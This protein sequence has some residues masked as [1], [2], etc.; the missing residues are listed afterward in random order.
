MGGWIDHVWDSTKK[1][2]GFP[3]LAELDSPMFNSPMSTSSTSSPRGQV[4]LVGAGPGDP[5]LV[6]LRA[7]QCLQRA[8]CVLYD[9]LVNPQILRHARSDAERIRL[10]RRSSDRLASQ[11]EINRELVERATRGQVVVRLKGGDPLVFGRL[12]EEA[13][14][15]AA[16]RIPFEIVP[17]ISTALAAAAYAGTPITHRDFASAVAFVTGQQQSD[18]QDSLLDFEALARFPGTLVLYM[19]VATAGR[20]SAEL[21]RAGKPAETPVA[22]VKHCSLPSQQTFRC[23]LDEVEGRLSHPEKVHPPAVVIVGQAAE[24]S[25]AL[26]WFSQRPLFGQ[27]VLVTRPADQTESLT[28]QLAEQ[29]AEVLVQPAIEICD[30]P[31]FTPVDQSIEQLQDY[32]WVVFSSANGVRYFLKRLLQTG[33]DLRAMG[34]IRLACIGPGTAEALAG[35]YLRA[36]LIPEQFRAESLA[37]A[38]RPQVAGKRI[39]LVRASRGREVLAEELAA[40]G[41]RVEQIVAYFSG[42]VQQ[43]DPAIRSR[44]NR[45][46][47]DWITVTSSA[48]ARS[49]VN[50]FGK[51]LG[52]A[53]LASISPITSGVLR[54]LGFE[55]TAEASNYTIEGVLCSILSSVRQQ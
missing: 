19:G 6:T 7:V 16:H 36:D 54:E 49:L 9:Y 5:A 17:G 25:E 34:G 51:D 33:R 32:D 47:I 14:Q 46:E 31:D 50:L 10:G 42:D 4:Y 26:D 38:L 8:D 23:R 44:L 18:Q 45:G 20:W 13:Q 52:N 12:A 24:A 29:G 53:K 3:S 21:I 41:A 1:S 40:A 2:P 27:T 48:I 35:Y 11:P 39:L 30:P 55:V 22:I 43:A 28:D 15:L 37:D